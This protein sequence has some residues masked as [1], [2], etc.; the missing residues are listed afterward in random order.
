MPVDD[1]LNPAQ[2][3]TLAALGAGDRDARSEFDS[4]I[5]GE[6]RARLEAGLTDVVTRSRDDRVVTVAKHLLNGMHGCQARYLHEQQQPFEPSVPIV[7]GTIAHKALEL[8]VHW[9]GVPLPLELVDQAIERIGSADHWATDFVATME[10]AERAELRAAAAE[11][12]NKFVE[13]W[14]PLVPAMRPATEAKMWAELCG[15]RIVLKGQADL[16]LGQPIGSGTRARKVIVDYKTGGRSPE[17]RSDLRFYALVETLRLGVPPRLVVTA[18]LNT[19]TLETEVITADV[20]TAT[21]ARVVDGVAAHVALTTGDSEPVRRP[22][23]VCRWCALLEDCAVG[24]SF[25]ADDR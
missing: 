15:G 22:S 11:I 17:H 12:V 23:G 13:S 20:L 2:R 1:A 21:V 6:L 24:Q 7:K 16:T 8:A 10:P 25:L 14:P 3:A 18:Y 9:P 4:G 5:A 19:A